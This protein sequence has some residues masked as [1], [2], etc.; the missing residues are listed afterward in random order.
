MD[1]EKIPQDWIKSLI[2]PI[3][4]KYNRNKVENYRGIT[5]LNTM[6]KVLSLIILK[7][8]QIFTDEVVGDYQSGFRKNKSKTDHILIIRKVMEKRYEF[9]N[10]LHMIV[11]DY[12]KAYDS[13]HW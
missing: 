10:D 3:F 11:V 12:K 5:L 4:K 7:M 9:A 13:I 8:L 2:C 6:Y 1:K